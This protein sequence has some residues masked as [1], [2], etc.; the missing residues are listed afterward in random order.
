M[1]RAGMKSTQTPA[2]MREDAR[3]LVQGYPT[4]ERNRVAFVYLRHLI[5]TPD[6]RYSLAQM[7]AAAEGLELGIKDGAA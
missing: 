2:Q 4:T 5:T 7:R 3:T 6:F 1:P